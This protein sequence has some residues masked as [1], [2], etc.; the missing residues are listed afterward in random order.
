[1][2]GS[3]KCKLLLISLVLVTLSINLHGQYVKGYNIPDS[4]YLQKH[5]PHKATFYSAILPGLGQIYNEKYW[6]VPII[7]AGFTGLIYYAGYNNHAYQGYKEGY[8]IRLKINAGD[9]TLTD[10]YEGYTDASILSK[11]EEWRRYR[12]ITFIAIG[13]LYVA[14][15]IDANVD[16]HLFDYDISDDL[17]LR[18]DPIYTD[19]RSAILTYS[20]VTKSSTIGL[21]CTIRF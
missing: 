21:R 15:I 3:M 4:T 10:L 18:F 11:R 16:A 12:E 9:T 17:S 14:Q 13:L 5:L 20:G 8:E 1:M 6:K 7:Y 2:L 19:P